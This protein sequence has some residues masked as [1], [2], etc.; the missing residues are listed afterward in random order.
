[1]EGCEVTGEVE[2]LESGESLI[3]DR[4]DVVF[5]CETDQSGDFFEGAHWVRIRCLVTDGEKPRRNERNVLRG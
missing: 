4:L 3:F 2:E 1:M 5:V